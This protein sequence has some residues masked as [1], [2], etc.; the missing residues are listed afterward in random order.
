MED[1]K[2]EATRMEGI[3][4]SAYC[5][6][7]ATSAVDSSAGFLNRNVSSEYIY[8]QNTAGE[9]FY[10]CNNM[11][12]FDNDVEQAQLNMR[13][14]VMQERIL[15]RRTIHFSANQTYWECGEGIYC[16]NLTKLKW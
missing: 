5:T 16:E 14:W 4:A 7:A 10:I 11:E 15:A 8:A 2:Y 13:A 1:W 6:I 12:D 3:Y 9:Q